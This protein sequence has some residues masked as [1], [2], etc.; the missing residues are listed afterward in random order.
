MAKLQELTALTSVSDSDKLVTVQ[1]QGQGIVPAT[2]LRDYVN[3][4]TVETYTIEVKDGG[5]SAE[6]IKTGTATLYKSGRV[7]T[8]KFN[9]SMSNIT[10][11]NFMYIAGLPNLGDHYFT[12]VIRTDGLHYGNTVFQLLGSGSNGFIYVRGGYKGDDANPKPV[13][14]GE[15]AL[16]A[17]EYTW[18]S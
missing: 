14:S 18:V 8:L 6:T 5:A 17:C 10:I 2:V 9:I 13:F 3:N 11:S 1:A 12:G 7:K 4:V 15:F 16:L